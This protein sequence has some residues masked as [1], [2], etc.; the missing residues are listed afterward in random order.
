MDDGTTTAA[1]EAPETASGGES[2]TEGHAAT[3]TDETVNLNDLPSGDEIGD[4]TSDDNADDDH[5]EWEKDGKKYRVPKELKPHLMKDADYTRKTQEVAETR[6]A[7][8]ARQAEIAQQAERAKQYSDDQKRLIFAEHQLEQ[9]SKLNWDKLYSDDP[10][11]APKHWMNFQRWKEHA[12]QLKTRISKADEDRALETQ[13]AFAK[14]VEDAFSY[15]EREIKGW[16]HETGKTLERY[17]IERL[18]FTPQQIN[19]SLTG[20][21]IKAVHGAWMWEQLQ[22]KQSA[23]KP[24]ETPAPEIK[25]TV[26]VTRRAS[27]TPASRK[28]LAA[29]EMDEYVAAR[30]AGRKH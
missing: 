17:A 2:Q 22:Q 8:E 18:G 28:S 16:K 24:S 30:K 12:D 20:P 9:F 26:E 11:E 4:Q 19:E 25:P 6:K 21:F 5:D 3:T 14:R 1:T 7:L 27:G 10:L 15:A 13:Q 29:M 23:P